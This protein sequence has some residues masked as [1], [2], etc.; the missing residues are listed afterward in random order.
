MFARV[1]LWIDALVFMGLGVWL[2][3]DPVESLR[4][5]HVTASA[6]AGV[7]ELRAMYGGLELGVGLFLAMTAMRP[8]WRDAGLWLGL[9]SIGGL[10]VVRTLSALLAASSPML[11]SFVALELTTTALH[12][13]AIARSPPADGATAHR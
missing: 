6:P 4:G 10:G 13:V 8:R 3:V 9:L 7:T 12:A 5:V 11:W 2:C 1:L